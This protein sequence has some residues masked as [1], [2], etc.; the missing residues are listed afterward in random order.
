LPGAVACR[1]SRL[2]FFLSRPDGTGQGHYYG[3]PDGTYNAYQTKTGNIGLGDWREISG[4]VQELVELPIDYPGVDKL[5]GHNAFLV[6]NGVISDPV[7][8]LISDR[9]ED[10]IRQQ[11]RYAPLVV[12]EKPALLKLFLDAQ[13]HF[14]PRDLPNVRSFLELYL[15]DGAALL[16]RA[17][18]FNV[19]DQTIPGTKEKI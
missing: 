19:L 11:R 1:S 5:R 10:N 15:T 4:E 17:R 13:R 3:W 8:V 2:V 14:I 16:P 7:R 9:N 12:I 18:L 6:T